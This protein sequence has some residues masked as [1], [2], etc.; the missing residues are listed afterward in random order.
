MGGKSFPI[1]RP[2]RCEAEVKGHRQEEEADDQ[3]DRSSVTAEIDT[4]AF[5]L[6]SF[7]WKIEPV[8][9]SGHFVGSDGITKGSKLYSEQEKS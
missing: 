7:C 9:L 1:T 4:L 2:S 3:V 6:G 5:S 8:F